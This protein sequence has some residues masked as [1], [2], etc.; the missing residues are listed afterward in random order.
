MEENKKEF[1]NAI[2]EQKVAERYRENLVLTTAKLRMDLV[3]TINGSHVPPTITLS[4]LREIVAETERVSREEIEKAVSKR[5]GELSKE[6]KENEKEID[7]T[8]RKEK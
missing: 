6:L 7:K 5:Q 2:N 3:N 1:M 4:V 8:L